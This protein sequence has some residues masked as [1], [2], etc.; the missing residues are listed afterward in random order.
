MNDFIT[1]SRNKLTRSD[2]AEP[3]YAMLAALQSIAAALLSIATT[4]IAREER[5][6]A[7][8]TAERECT[9]CDTVFIAED[10]DEDHCAACW[11]NPMEPDYDALANAEPT[12]ATELQNCGYPVGAVGGC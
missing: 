8:I 12:T 5:Y 11:V 2:V 6:Q 9:E 7:K 1:I 3:P 10:P 4:L